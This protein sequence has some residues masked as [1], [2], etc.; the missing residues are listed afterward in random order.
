MHT[1]PTCPVAQL[2]PVLWDLAYSAT[3]I[4]VPVA[5]LKMTL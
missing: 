1:L 3:A 4:N 5:L 2:P